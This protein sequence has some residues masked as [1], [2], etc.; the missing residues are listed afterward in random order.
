MFRVR[1]GPIHRIP[2]SYFGGGIKLRVG[3]ILGLVSSTVGRRDYT[4]VS[5][6]GLEA[7]FT[8]SYSPYSTFTAPH[9]ALPAMQAYQ[10]LFFLVYGIEEGTKY[11]VEYYNP[12][13]GDYYN[14]MLW[15]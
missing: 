8:C 5:K 2:E 4:R 14:P 9:Y 10:Y 13:L 3:L 1:V 12:S 11:R 7:L 6:I 15:S